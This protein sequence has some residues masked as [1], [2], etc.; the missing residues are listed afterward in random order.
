MVDPTRRDGHTSTLNPAFSPR[1]KPT[2]PR[3]SSFRLDEGYSEDTRSQTGSELRTD[4]RMG[5]ASEEEVTQTVLPAWVY[6]MTEADRSEF[7]HLM[8]GSLRTSSVA[9]IVDRLYPR[10]H[11]DPII[12]LPPEI[13][14]EIFRYLD[15]D[16]LL[17]T[18]SLSHIWRARAL[19]VQ[20]WRRLYLAEGW[21]ADFDK[22]KAFEQR[23]PRRK[24]TGRGKARVRPAE[25]GLES[26]KKSPKR[27]TRDTIMSEAQSTQDI[28]G[29]RVEEWAEQHG[30]IEVDDDEKMDDI[31]DAIPS[32]DATAP[33]WTQTSASGRPPLSRAESQSIEDDS[34]LTT[35]SDGS[36]PRLNWQHL[37][38]QKRRLEAN[39]AAGRYTNFSLPH[40]SHPQE[41]HAE[42]VYTIQYTTK[43]LVSGSRDKTL[44]IWNLATQ[45]LMVPPLRG[46]D[47]SVLCLQFDDRPDQDIVVSGGSDCHIILWKFSTGQMLKKIDRAHSEP[48]LNLRFNDRYLVT[49]SKDKTIKVWNR[50]AILPTDDAYPIMGARHDVLFPTY[51]VDFKSL[52]RDQAMQP[53]KEFSLLMTL[54]GHSAAVNAIQ[55]YDDQIVSASG[56]RNIKIWDVRT[57]ACLKQFTGHVKGI[58]CVQFDGRRIVSGSSDETVR[59]FD[60]VTGAEVACLRG[61]TNLVRT[62]QAQFGDT[63]T[64]IADDELKAR[65]VD[66]GY[67]DAVRQG[68][69]HN[70]PLSREERRARNAGS[71]DPR[72]LFAVGAKLP[73]GGGGSKWAR[74]V[75]GSYDETVIIWKRA[76]DGR[77]EPAHQLYQWQAVV[78]AGAQPR[79]PFAG[80]SAQRPQAP[81]AAGQPVQPPP[82]QG[83]IGQNGQVHQAVAGAQQGNATAVTRTQVQIDFDRQQRRLMRATQD[84]PSQSGA[85]SVVSGPSNAATAGSAHS[86]HPSPAHVAASNMPQGM[87]SQSSQ[88]PG[89]ASSSQASPHHSNDQALA[90]AASLSQAAPRTHHHHHHYGPQMNHHLQQQLA[91]G[92]IP[93]HHHH[94]HPPQAAPLTAQ[95]GAPNAGPHPLPMN[96]PPQVMGYYGTNSRVFKLQF[97]SRRII[98]CSQDPT[99][100]GWDFA[101]GDRDIMAASEF[102]GEEEW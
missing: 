12:H 43:H 11:L 1:Y 45:R 3:Q 54:H 62:V 32:D 73:P 70:V 4:S 99:I 35:P 29:S 100:V 60:R 76:A 41:A 71:S 46:H 85:V 39:W 77:W 88:H 42:C 25:D 75:S 57:G 96:I 92:Q 84:D 47:A 74:I 64:S 89:Q 40:P 98:C 16:A 24:L 86:A 59:I 67:R 94:H 58:A 63:T 8:L 19:D 83:F 66:A 37:Y 21:K 50:H 17:R 93:P 9:A 80:P 34:L 20:L 2:A 15:A 55:I 6:N 82:A 61:H 44:R 49:C 72:S 5:E 26:E 10:L 18:S 30:A 91:T 51:I 31:A 79:G 81:P 52:D 68:R 95:P 102:F 14:A 23:Q 53:L 33:A 48:V 78:N 56:D 69:V 27:R 97:D 7:V 28:P 87:A 36:T 38:K 65:T 101:N 22:I 90:Q 13:T